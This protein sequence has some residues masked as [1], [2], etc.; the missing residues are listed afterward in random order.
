MILCQLHGASLDRQILPGIVVLCLRIGN[1]IA[2]LAQKI[3]LLQAIF[4]LLGLNH[5]LI[6]AG[7]DDV[8]DGNVETQACVAISKPSGPVEGVKR[9]GKVIGTKISIEGESREHE[10]SLIERLGAQQILLQVEL[11]QLHAICHPASARSTRSGYG[12][13]TVTSS[14]MGWRST[15]AAI[16]AYVDGEPAWRPVRR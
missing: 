6:S 12:S 10:F 14:R 4:R 2:S 5:I 15:T 11:G 8:C 3:L 1:L 13:E 7:L 9:I 16:L